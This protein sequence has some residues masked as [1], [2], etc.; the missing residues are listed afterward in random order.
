VRVFIA[1]GVLA[2]TIA[3]SACESKYA[4]LTPE[5]Q[6]SMLADLRA[7]KLNLDCD[8]KC[9]LTWINQAPAIHALDIAERWNDL[10]I[11]VMQVG[12]G[13]D[14]AY[15]Y[16][17]QAAQGLGYHQAAIGYYQ[18]S[19]AL[20]NGQDALKRC[21]GNAE[22]LGNDPCQGVDLQASIPVLIQAS[23]TAIAEA[24]A[25]AEAAARPAPVIHHRHKKP[26]APAAPKW[27]MPDAPPPAT[28]PS[29]TP[30]TSQ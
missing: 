11:K 2:G 6:A 4:A 13:Q 24:A 27:V 10:A 30:A 9:S 12:Y 25:A 16:L 5:L 8:T 17:G 22:N 15:Y 19:L 14:L 1:F 18:Y 26:V 28:T 29:S 7:G 21:E 23:Q 3:L 20:S